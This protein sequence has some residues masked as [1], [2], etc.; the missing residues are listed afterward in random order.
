[1]SVTTT[2]S[3][4]PRNYNYASI[5]FVMLMVFVC[6]LFFVNTST[7]TTQYDYKISAVERN[8][9]ELSIKRE[10][11][12]VEKARLTSIAMAKNSTIA[13]AMEDATISGYAAD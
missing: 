7:A 4:V 6:G 8:I 11:L 5:A 12:A 13:M 10:D 9:S 2:R 3:I 1:M